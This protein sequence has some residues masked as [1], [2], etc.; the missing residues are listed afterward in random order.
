[1]VDGAGFC[2]ACGEPLTFRG[3]RE[4][5]D[6]NISHD[7]SPGMLYVCGCGRS[8]VWTNS[9]RNP[10]ELMRVIGG[11]Q[12]HPYIAGFC[13]DKLCPICGGDIVPIKNGFESKWDPQKRYDLLGCYNGYRGDKHNQ[14]I[15]YD[16]R[17]ELGE[18]GSDQFIPVFAAEMGVA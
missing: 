10:E 11:Q 18:D 13:N 7:Y 17:K 9:V 3:L 15:V 1:M 16:F 14:L 8:Q 6:V 4:D 12:K 2:E 5:T